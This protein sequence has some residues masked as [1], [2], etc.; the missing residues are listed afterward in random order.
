M[1]GLTYPSVSFGHM[2]LTE[3]IYLR[4]GVLNSQIYISLNSSQSFFKKEAV[5][6]SDSCGSQSN[7]CD[8]TVQ[9]GQD[10]VNQP[11]VL[12]QNLLIYCL[13]QN[14][15]LPGAHLMRPPVSVHTVLPVIK[16][17]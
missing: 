2:C 13:G 15:S 6:I 9:A 7:I 1:A 5:L 10:N 11:Q 16:P 12:L 4:D 8:I 17:V 3:L 14:I